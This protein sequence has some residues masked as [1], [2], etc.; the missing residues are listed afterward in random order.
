YGP[1]RR[2]H[3]AALPPSLHS[4]GAHA[5]RSHGVGI[6][7]ARGRALPEPVRWGFKGLF[8]FGDPGSEYGQGLEKYISGDYEFYRTSPKGSWRYGM[9]IGFGSFA[10]KPPYQDEEEFALLRTYFTAARV[11][12]LDKSVRPYLELQA[13]AARTHPRSRLFDIQ[14]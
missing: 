7:R 13:G 1:S 5:H 6:V 4:C 12:R 2:T 9:G 3:A 14:P 8:D 11:F 10:L